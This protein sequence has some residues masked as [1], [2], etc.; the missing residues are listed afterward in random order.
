MRSGRSPGNS[1]WFIPR[2]EAPASRVM[3]DPF[4]AIPLGEYDIG[5]PVPQGEDWDN[6]VFNLVAA[7]NFDITF[8]EAEGLLLLAF[9]YLET[10]SYGNPTSQ[11]VVNAN[12]N[13]SNAVQVTMQEKDEGIARHSQAYSLL[14][15]IL[16]VWQDI[17]THTGDAYWSNMIT[18]QNRIANL[19]AWETIHEQNMAEVYRYGLRALFWESRA[20][21]AEPNGV[22]FYDANRKAIANFEQGILYANMAIGQIDSYCPTIEELEIELFNVMSLA[23]QGGVPG[24][25]YNPDWY[26]Q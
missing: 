9:N 18:V 22:E 8:N 10:A 24:Y 4:Q 19:N 17:N 23:D 20:A 21:S 13:Y 14:Y 12:Y 25:E 7:T 5:F 15:D 2:E 3:G 26:P 6:E 11:G 1:L 16:Q